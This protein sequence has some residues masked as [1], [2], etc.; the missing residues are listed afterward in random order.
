MVISLVRRRIIESESKRIEERKKNEQGSRR[1][2]TTIY[3]AFKFAR[4]RKGVPQGGS[5]RKETVGVEMSVAFSYLNR[6]GLES[7]F[8]P[9][10]T[11]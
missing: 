11:F 8:R 4:K 5:S 6:K 2:K 7:R 9:N 1:Q 10:S 3:V